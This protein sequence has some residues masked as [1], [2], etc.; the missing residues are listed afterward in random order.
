MVKETEYYEVLGVKP[1]AEDNQIKKAYRRLA[2]KFHPDKPTGDE[3]KFKQIGE[4]Y[5]VLSDEKKRKLYDD[6]GKKGLEEGGGP[7]GDASD[8]FSRFFGRGGKQGEPKPKDIVHEME[9]RLEEFY[10]G[11]T[12]K[13]AVVRNRKCGTCD[14]SGVKPDSGKTRE[15]FRCQKCGGLGYRNMQRMI[16]PGF[17]QQVRV[18]CDACGGEGFKIPES[19]KCTACGGKRTVRDRKVLEVFIEKGARRGDT[20]L[21]QGEGDQN[22]DMKQSGDV[23]IML[24]QAPHKFF[25]RRGRHLFFDHKITLEEALSGIHLPI[26]HL[27]GRKI[28]LKTRPGQVLDP[29]KI[30]FIDREGMPL[31]GTGGAEKGSLVINLEVEFPKKLSVQQAKKLKDALGEPDP[32]E[33][34]GPVTQCNLKEY[35]PKSKPRQQRAAHPMAGMMGMM[36]GDD[37]DDDDGP[38]MGGMPG[39]GGAQQVQCQ[40]Q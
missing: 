6:H 33:T 40:H 1:D 16:G 27:D 13:I 18:P 23:M 22:P 38:G 15:D 5:E 24:A 4:A 11:K 9:I 19:M 31:K 39:M 3:A 7:S 25:Q 17:V 26:E 34:K 20:V 21:L 2:Q 14:A 37:D 30:W 36:G 8:I 10:A 29:Q 12:K 35:V 28:L 32:L